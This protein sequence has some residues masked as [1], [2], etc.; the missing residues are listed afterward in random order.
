MDSASHLR[1]PASGPYS[2]SRSSA[3]RQLSDGQSDKSSTPNSSPRSSLSYS[4]TM[5]RSPM[6]KFS[7]SP[8]PS[9]KK[10]S[11]TNKTNEQ[12]SSPAPNRISSALSKFERLD[13]TSRLSATTGLKSVPRFS[14]QN[15]ALT[16]NNNSSNIGGNK[17]LNGKSLNS[18]SSNRFGLNSTKNTQS[19]RMPLT[20]SSLKQKQ[21]GAGRGG[22]FLMKKNTEGKEGPKRSIKKEDKDQMVKKLTP[23]QYRV[24][25]EKIT[26]R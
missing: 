6:S 15:S 26:E 17:F 13:Q 23:M 14:Q 18:V 4:P 22:G 5:S 8:S 24:T 11:S 10:F 21:G 7:D 9:S 25:Q 12:L 1:R 3:D 2:S 16:S 19:S 20:P